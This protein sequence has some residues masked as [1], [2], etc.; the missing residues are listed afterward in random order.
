MTD[1]MT[2]AKAHLY[3]QYRLPYASEMVDDLL[4]YMGE[5]AVVADIGAG[6][7]QLARL[8]AG[9]C[10]AVYA[11][12]PDAA[13]R[14]VATEVLQPHPNICVIN[15]SAEQTTLAENSVDLVVIGNAYHRF[16]PEAIDELLHILKPS[17]WIAVI[18]YVF[19]NKAF[20]NMLF[21]KLSQ[22]PGF[23]ARSQQN[24]HQM[25]LERLF[26]AQPVH[27]LHYVQSVAV[28]WEA[29]WGSACSGIEAPDAHDEEFGQFEAINREV[30]N[31]FS[32][33]G[34]MRMDYEITV[35]FGQPKTI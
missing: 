28:D 7:G 34:R 22:L 23:A 19:N 18:R 24:W 20:A 11:V 25:P 1:G 9:T 8:F 10:N 26:G 14:Q 31:A 30:F 6:T 21:P 12:E 4:K 33:A 32:D 17:G 5:I 15:G 3:E 29:F 35:S 2:L 13:M 27:T 16:K